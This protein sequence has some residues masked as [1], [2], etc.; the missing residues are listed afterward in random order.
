[1]CMYIC[2]PVCVHVCM[3]VYVFVHKNSCYLSVSALLSTTCAVVEG[4][5]GKQ[6]KILI[7]VRVASRRPWYNSA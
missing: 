4:V 6:L 3:C 5:H 1:M 7:I 2:A